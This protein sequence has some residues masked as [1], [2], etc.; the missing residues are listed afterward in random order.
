MME[1]IIAAAKLAR[2][3]DFIMELSDG[4]NTMA[5]EGGRSLSSGKKQRIS[6][7]R[8]ILKD[9]PVILLNEAAASPDPENEAEIQRAFE[10]LTRGRTIVVIACRFSTIRN[11][12]SIL[13]LNEGGIAEQG[14]CDELVQLGGIYASLREEQQKTAEWKLGA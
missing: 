7:S 1:E 10:N 4:Y 9:A 13:V 5:A 6:I 2:C 3:H 8:A 12:D 14:T 11:A